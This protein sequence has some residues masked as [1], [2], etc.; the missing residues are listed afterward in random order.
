M[1]GMDPYSSAATINVGG[2]MIGGLMGQ[3]SQRSA[4]ATMMHLHDKNANLQAAFAKRGIQWK[5]DDMMKAAKKHGIHPLAMMGMQGQSYSPQQVGIVP[6]DSMANAV[7]NMGQDISRAYAASATREQKNAAVFDQIIQGQQIEMN[8][9]EIEAKRLQLM[10]TMNSP[11]TAS[12]PSPVDGPVPGQQHPGYT[13]KPAEVTASD[14][15]NLGQEAGA[16]NDYGFARTSTG[17][18]VVPSKDVKERIEDQFIPETMWA[19]R[20]MLKPPPPASY[21]KDYHWNP[22]AQEYQH[23]DSNMWYRV[24]KSSYMTNPR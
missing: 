5:M 1:F 10:K 8:N 21:M 2:Q 7:S 24:N 6:E 19:I 4:N 17:Y 15:K 16:I 20:N 18:A 22:V 13:V 11:G 12:M 14:S 3:S 23:K 9:L